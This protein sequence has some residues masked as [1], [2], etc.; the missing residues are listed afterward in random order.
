MR[1][2]RLQVRGRCC[3]QGGPN[4]APAGRA[5]DGQAVGPRITCTVLMSAV[6]EEGDVEQGKGGKKA[7]DPLHTRDKTQGE[8]FG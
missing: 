3:N 2:W 4:T 1:P 6:V 5:W 8:K 7:P